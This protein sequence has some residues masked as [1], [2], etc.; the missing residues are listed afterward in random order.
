MAHCC[1]AEPAQRSAA[2]YYATPLPTPELAQFDDVIVE[3]LNTT[4]RNIKFLQREGSQVFAY[5]SLG[6]ISDTEAKRFDL[7]R[8]WLLGRNTAWRSGVVDQTNPAWRQWVLNERVST[9]VAAGYDG[10][11]FDTLDSFQLVADTENKQRRQIAG[12]IKL[13]RSIHTQY[14]KLKLYFN[15]GFELLP[16]LHDVVY[17]L[18]V[19][20]LFE[21][22]NAQRKK[23]V[24]VTDSDRQWLLGKLSEVKALGIPVTV[25][26]YVAPAERDKAAKTAQKIKAQGFVPWVSVAALDQ[27]GVGAVQVIPRRVLVVYDAKQGPLALNSA[28]ILLGNALDYLGMRIDYHDIRAGMPTQPLTGLYA[29]VVTWLQDGSFSHF[30][31]FEQWLAEQLDNQIPLVVFNSLPLQNTRLLAKLGLK[32]LQQPLQKPLS[33]ATQ[34]P[35]IGHY[36]API[37][38]KIRDIP[39]ITNARKKNT[40]WL[41][42]QGAKGNT[43]DPVLIA[44]WGGMALYPYVNTET[45]PGFKRWII[46]PF[47]FLR[48]A[49][50]INDFPVADSTTES[51]SRILTSHVDGDGFVSRAELPNA[52]YSAEVLLE[53]IFKRYRLPHTVS[54]IEGEVGKQG[55]Y[56]KQSPALEKIARDIFR[57]PNVELASHSFSH[58]FF[59]QPNKMN[60]GRR[61]E[62]GVSMPIPNYSVDYRREVIGS[63]DY[64]NTRLAPPGK[65]VKVMLWTGDALP[66]AAAIALTQEAGVVNFNGGNT[67]VTNA[68]PSTTAVYPQIR[69]TAAGPQIYAPIMNENV[70]TNEWH[71]PYYGFRQVIETF[72]LT[73]LPRRFKPIAI[74]WHFY[75]GTKQSALQALYDIYDWAKAQAHTAMYIS[76]YA[77][78]VE[79]TYTTSFARTAEGGIQVRGLGSLRTLRIAPS[80][81]YPDLRRSEGVAGFIDLPQ[82]RYLHLSASSAKLYFQKRLDKKQPYLLQANAMVDHWR[83]NSKGAEMRLTAHEPIKLQIEN[84]NGCRI[85]TRNKWRT[86]IKRGTRQSFNLGIRDTQNALLVCQ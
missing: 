63:I 40:P 21:G 29:G 7:P 68:Y 38:L 71:G 41:S 47:E 77:P 16:E 14:P 75:S 33:I 61:K 37:K 62:Y 26:D 17:A 12:L 72:K 4:A 83:A 35:H 39:G 45:R 81:G 51:G 65:K 19:E 30:K 1:L 31:L 3:P 32:R 78:K 8:D 46:E 24:P 5:L 58:P 74:Y 70:Y 57:L 42:L 22:W 86:G 13:I 11:F 36:E 84:A 76:E 18:A 28:H 64:I 49:L 67:K 79:G 80:L 2:F 52:P 23:Y 43:A 9:L 55:L 20:S 15:R 53:R 10:L 82:G 44:P 54:V 6:E 25:I 60:T 50:Q 56:P 69:P 27:L 34:V 48:S 59:W 73:D 66:G 85:K